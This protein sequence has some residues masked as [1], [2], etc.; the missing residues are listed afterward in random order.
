M[1]KNILSFVSQYLK[2]CGAV[3]PFK[4]FK[5]FSEDPSTMWEHMATNVI[6]VVSIAFFVLLLSLID[7]R[8]QVHS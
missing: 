8:A 7:T 4:E 5:T 3:A 2:C 1:F 6:Q